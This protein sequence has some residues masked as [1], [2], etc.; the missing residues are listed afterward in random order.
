MN[1]VANS[2]SEKTDLVQ[3]LV[4]NGSPDVLV[5]KT[6]AIPV[7]YRELVE[8]RTRADHPVDRPR[9][10][11]VEIAFTDENAQV[12]A[13]IL[14]RALRIGQFLP[15]GF[16]GDN[17]LAKQFAVAS[18]L[19]HVIH[20]RE[21]VVQGQ[22][23][24]V[25]SVFVPNT[26][27]S[28]DL[29]SQPS[30]SFIS[31]EDELEQSDAIMADLQRRFSSLLSTFDEAKNRE[32]Q[33]S[34]ELA[35]LRV[36]HQELEAVC[37][38]WKNQV[39]YWSSHAEIQDAENVEI[40]QELKRAHA[41]LSL[42][43]EDLSSA[44]IRFNALHAEHQLAR[45][46]LQ[47][48]EEE[49]DVTR[50]ALNAVRLSS[51][52]E[53]KILQNHLTEIK[54]DLAVHQGESQ[55]REN[56]LNQEVNKH[57]L[58]AE[59]AEQ[60]MVKLQDH[61][62]ETKTLLLQTSD[63]TQI[64]S[65]ENQ[66]L[67]EQLQSHQEE[68]LTTKESVRVLE[69][70]Y[71]EA[72][73]D[74]QITKGSLN[75]LQ[76]SHE[77]LN[78]LLVQAQGVIIQKQQ[79]L[80]R[81]LDQ[82]ALL[83]A[84]L[85]D[86]V[87]QLKQAQKEANAALSLVETSENEKN[88]TRAHSL[89]LQ[90]M[91]DDGL[92][93]LALQEQNKDVLMAELNQLQ[94]RF[95][96]LE[97]LREDLTQQLAERLTQYEAACESVKTAQE[98]I[99]SQNNEIQSWME[100]VQAGENE[101]AE[102][103]QIQKTLHESLV[104][105]Q[106]QLQEQQE[107]VAQLTQSVDQL[108][109]QLGVLNQDKAELT[110]KVN[111]ATQTIEAMLATHQENQA[112]IVQFKT[113]A[114]AQ[115]TSLQDVQ[116][117]L[118][119][120]QA[121][122]ARAK[123]DNTNRSQ[124]MQ[125]LLKSNNALMEELN[126]ARENVL[127][128]TQARLEITSGLD[129][130]QKSLNQQEQRLGAEVKKWQDLHAQEQALVTNLSSDVNELKSEI[131]SF[132]EAQSRWIEQEQGLIGQIQ[133][134]EA[135]RVELEQELHQAS[136]AQQQLQVQHQQLQE[137]LAAGQSHQRDLQNQYDGQ[138]EEVARLSEQLTQKD[139]QY[140]DLLAEKEVLATKAT[141][142]LEQSAILQEQNEKVAA[143]E[144]DLIAQQQLLDQQQTT[145]ARLQEERLKQA[146]LS[147]SQSVQ[148][149]TTEKALEE[150]QAAFVLLEETVNALRQEES[151]LKSVLVSSQEE[152]AALVSKLDAQG[153]ALI[154]KENDLKETSSSLQLL[155]QQHDV[156]Q[157][158]HEAELLKSQDLSDHF[159]QTQQALT[160]LQGEWETQQGQLVEKAELLAVANHT[161]S[162]L[163]E[164]HQALKTKHADTQSALTKTSQELAQ[165]QEELD[166]A[167]HE[168]TL[169]SDALKQHQEELKETAEALRV[170]QNQQQELQLALQENQQR[171]GV[172][173]Q[174][175][176]EA[177]RLMAETQEKLDTNEQ[178]LDEARRA[179]LEKQTHCASLEQALQS[180][181]AHLSL[182]QEQL[183]AT[184]SDLAANQD[185]IHAAQVALTQALSDVHN[186]S[187]R[188]LEL[189]THALQGLEHQEALNEQVSRLQEQFAL[190]KQSH[191]SLQQA[192]SQ[193]EQVVAITKEKCEKLEIDHQAQL[194]ELAKLNNQIAT[195]NQE[196][197]HIEDQWA[198][199]QKE[200]AQ[201]Q[202]KLAQSQLQVVSLRQELVEARNTFE[203]TLLG[204]DET[205]ESLSQRNQELSVLA[206]HL[207]NRLG[208]YVQQIQALNEKCEELRHPSVNVKLELDAATRGREQAI[209][210]LQKVRTALDESERRRVMEASETLP[211]RQELAQAQSQIEHLNKTLD[212]SQV[213][214][215]SVTQYNAEH[216]QE[217]V[218]LRAEL[219]AAREA[220]ELAKQDKAQVTEQYLQ[221][222]Q[223]L[224]D[225]QTR[226]TARLTSAVELHIEH[227]PNRV[228]TGQ[229]L[230]GEGD[231]VISQPVSEGAR[232]EAEGSVHIYG[233]M[234]GTVH[235]G[236]TGNKNAR[237]FCLNFGAQ[238]VA[239]AGHFCQLET[240]PEELRG[241]A[242][243]I[244]LDQDEDILRIAPIY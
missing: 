149:S 92:S 10:V 162:A 13:D 123:E 136:V 195:L 6:N 237:I 57:K 122:W 70:H 230:K 40:Q 157:S 194:S 174:Q 119:L 42:C 30:S 120:A 112:L 77:S 56:W 35:R 198:E 203:E 211:L 47:Q 22:H 66:V 55:V 220:E 41:M 83:D 179:L 79:E 44:S 99:Q 147:H 28:A 58:L 80:D 131:A 90:G 105:S 48:S 224:V 17:D 140:N 53:A 101:L 184:Q 173:E 205:V 72:L 25:P 169:Q 186:K 160:Q 51:L 161:V 18:S 218:A 210:E 71:Q 170:S 178:Q 156:L 12:R 241:K 100:Q 36:A 97:A 187:I 16:V 153:V 163:E 129:A 59:K 34:I 133:A 26:E 135:R 93:R 217:L 167:R 43:E 69:T 142:L 176:N 82:I 21:L 125:Q 106:S 219:Q 190:E 152:R 54:Q 64:L 189:E 177:Q 39:D 143:L 107:C 138:Q 139:N 158:A 212:Q 201:L 108:Q 172:V 29:S 146:E 49:L 188:V 60:D 126:A 130:A 31:Q 124:Q 52:E 91:I 121:G 1:A 202:E 95:E 104:A 215:E 207:E 226:H 166:R 196:N 94:E 150:A 181:E 243:E 199:L 67:A 141:Q 185:E 68:L 235:A 236:Y 118:V 164:N 200:H 113:Q 37:E 5:L 74:N 209:E 87:T 238:S 182:A 96:Q 27:E 62:N 213:N 78:Q 225:M 197:Q 3:L 86:A 223:A 117:Q 221:A 46:A 76:D 145:I 204:R 114:Q 229:E 168:F 239:I 9:E 216:H 85:D 24:E 88:E 214:V 208:S 127:S 63:Q 206:S 33:S 73:E 134:Y 137:A 234:N 89:V 65:Q 14:V 109:G 102:N 4:E 11:W 7:L 128:L 38:N 144:E 151:Q 233:P 61:L 116:Q 240:L 32:S 183:T 192:Y 227:H 242:V 50:D 191:Q 110:D 45:R 159:N 75:Q 103:Q 154:E 231:L 8:L 2:P 148:L 20:P 23:D 228:R 171:V 19:P 175:L 15:I 84:S 165:S 81:S 98:K 115:Q 155:I 180:N 232:V 193:V 244:W 222:R 132:T 111:E